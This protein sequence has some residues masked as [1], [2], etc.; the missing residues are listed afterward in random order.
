[1]TTSPWSEDILT[2]ESFVAGRDNGGIFMPLRWSQAPSSVG[3]GMSE[4]NVVSSRF[5][6]LDLS[7]MRVKWPPTR[8]DIQQAILLV[9]VNTGTVPS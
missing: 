1:M 2:S 7:V 5:G 4:G 6:Q 3:T 9:T 8:H